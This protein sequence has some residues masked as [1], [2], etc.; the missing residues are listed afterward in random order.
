MDPVL[1]LNPLHAGN[2]NALED[3]ARWAVLARADVGLSADY[4]DGS[5]DSVNLIAGQTDTFTHRYSV[6]GD[7]AV[8]F[9]LKSGSLDT[10]LKSSVN[11]AN[12]HKPAVAIADSEVNTK[13]FVGRYYTLHF[14][15][16]D[17]DRNMK[18]FTFYW[19]KNIV[20]YSLLKPDSVDSFPVQ[21]IWDSL[22]ERIKLKAILEDQDGAMDSVEREIVFETYL[23]PDVSDFYL[24]PDPALG[25]DDNS[26]MAVITVKSASS[27]LKWFD[28]YYVVEYPDT[29][30]K[31]N[32]TLLA[33]E[34]T[35][36][37]NHKKKIADTSFLDSLWV[38]AG[39][40]TDT[41]PISLGVNSD[42]ASH[43]PLDTN[44]LFKVIIRDASGASSLTKTAPFT[45]LR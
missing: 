28:F 34:T 7:H 43:V 17:P 23:V 19:G 4:G 18:L 14:K 33:P 16:T 32:D 5:R 25:V 24:Y 45:W 38:P 21:G 13:F 42:L 1:T 8:Q 40:L 31:S 15:V 11:V 44:I 27:Y 6:A 36:V 41:F 2:L 26:I 3:T 9:N 39:G 37:N 29:I 30:I 35:I 12:N 10:V 22:S 20:S